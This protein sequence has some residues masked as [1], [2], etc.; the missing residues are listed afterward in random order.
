MVTQNNSLEFLNI[1]NLNI[2]YNGIVKI[3]QSISEKGDK[4]ILVYEGN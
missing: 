4:I 3:K 1:S 2:E